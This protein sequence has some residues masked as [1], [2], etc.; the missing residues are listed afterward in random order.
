MEHNQLCRKHSQGLSWENVQICTQSVASKTA[1]SRQAHV[2]VLQNWSDGP[3]LI[4]S[5]RF[6]RLRPGLA[7]HIFGSSLEWF[8]FVTCMT[9][10]NMKHERFI[11]FLRRN[12][13]ACIG[14]RNFNVNF[15]RAAWFIELCWW[16]RG[17][18]CSLSSLARKLRCSVS[19]NNA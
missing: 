19:S 8:H 6:K 12:K 7:D 16:Q 9:R 2:K 4:L 5:S 15:A 3:G 14:H 13:E 18:S 17:I 10:C 11:F 1:A